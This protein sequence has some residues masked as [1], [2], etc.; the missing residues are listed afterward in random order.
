MIPHLFYYQLV[1]LG[2]LWLFG[3]LHSAWPSRGAPVQGT[4]A[5]PIKGEAGL[6]EQL[7]LYQTYYN[8]C[9]PHTSLH[10]LLACS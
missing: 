10:L 5:Q 6:R 1:I 8:F 7:A 4:A 2:L 3:M 9:L